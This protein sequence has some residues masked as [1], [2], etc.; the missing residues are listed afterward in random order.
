[1]ADAIDSKPVPETEAETQGD[2]YNPGKKIAMRDVYANLVGAMGDRHRVPPSFPKF[3]HL[4]H[5]HQPDPNSG[6]RH[7]LVDD[8]TGVVTQVDELAMIGFL[9]KWTRKERIA[10]GCDKYQIPY[11]VAAPLVEEWKCLQK[12]LINPV[13]MLWKDEPGY[14][15][16][17]LPWVRAEVAG[18]DTPLWDDLVKRMGPAN[19]LTFKAF[20]GS[21][22]HPQADVQQYLY[23][24]GHGGDGKG[25]IIRMLEKTLGKAFRAE[26]IP[27]DKD[28]FWTHGLLNI[29][30]AAIADADPAKMLQSGKIKSLLGGDSQRIEPKRKQSYTARLRVK[31]LISSNFKPEI[32]SSPADLRR[33]LY[34]HMPPRENKDFVPGYEDMLWAETGAFLHNCMLAYELACPNHEPIPYDQTALKEH[35]DELEERF[36]VFAENNFEFHPHE[37]VEYAAKERLGRDLSHVQPSVMD[38]R[39]RLEFRQQK[40]RTEFRAWLERKHGIKSTLVKLADGRVMRCYPGMSAKGFASVTQA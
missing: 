21:L 12:R 10:M 39:M 7:I 2:D 9:M 26:M 35:V 20:V 17:R 1:M 38:G 28:K 22:Y 33:C 29:R 13:D 19:E 32:S 34:I 16:H 14:T 25:T 11:K 3:P 36:S 30:L 40:E 37:M 5:A 24:H 31:L 6:V 4:V 23:L 8:G 18:Q 15:Y 27:D